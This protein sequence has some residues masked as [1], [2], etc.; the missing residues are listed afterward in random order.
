M[1]IVALTLL[2]ALTA[3]AQPAKLPANLA[4]EG[5][6]LLFDGE[7]LFGWTPEGKAEWRVVDGALIADS[8]GYGWLRHNS[9][10]DNFQLHV[11]FQTEAGGNSGVFLRAA[12]TGQ[13]HLT[14]YEL[15]IYDAHE[16]YPTGSI[17]GTGAAKE[18]K[19]KPGQWQAFD[20]LALGNQFIVKLDGRQVLETR[21]R[22]TPAGHIGLQFN[23][24]KP[25]AFRNIILKPLGL[26]PLVHGDTL[27][28]WR[29]VAPPKPPAEPAEWSVKDGVIHVEK[30]P[31]QLETEMTFANFVLQMQ[32]KTNPQDPTHHPNSGVF[33]RGAP[34]SWWSGYESQI[35]NE[36][37][38]GDPA[39][40]VD[41]GTGGIYR[42]QPARRI[43]ARDGEYFTKTIAAGGRQIAVWV[44]GN[45]VTSWED[46]NPEGTSVRE[47]QAVLRPGTISLQAHD[48]TTNLD[49]RNI[50]IAELPPPR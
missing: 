34:N 50:Q 18:G 27:K 11:E 30:G 35:R 37:S 46:P 12:K 10:F 49:F 6:L 25:V 28:G 16:R 21:D 2:L 43:V 42:N 22:K 36:Y 45:P 9:R 48:P 26:Q 17:L 24:G 1:R 29:E 19:I 23:P 13:P 44:N 8:G 31:G 4:A 47:K 33:F 7:S 14:G 20:V 38:G 32:I 39:K 41:F 40:P 3:L 15:Q 5:W